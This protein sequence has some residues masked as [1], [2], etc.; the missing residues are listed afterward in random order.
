MKV[1]RVLG[2]EARGVRSGKD[3][4]WLWVPSDEEGVEGRKG[5]HVEDL[6]IE[7]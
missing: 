7:E 1:L 6:E 2:D 4:L 5:G 3:G